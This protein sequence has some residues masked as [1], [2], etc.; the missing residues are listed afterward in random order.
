MKKFLKVIFCILFTIVFFI[1]CCVCIKIGLYMNEQRSAYKDIKKCYDSNAKYIMETKELNDPLGCY[2]KMFNLVLPYLLTYK[3]KLK[4]NVPLNYVYIDKDSTYYIPEFAIESAAALIG[5]GVG[6]TCKFEDNYVELF[7]K[8]VYAYDCGN[9]TNICA[10]AHFEPQCVGT[11]E[12]ALTYRSAKDFDHT[13]V[14]DNQ[15]HE[16]G[17]KIKE[18]GLENK[19]VLLKLNIVGAEDKVMDGILRYSDNIPVIL[20][21]IHYKNPKMMINKLKTL[22]TL[23]EKYYLVARKNVPVKGVV[24][25]IKPPLF[26]NKYVEG[27]YSRNVTLTYINKNLVE[28]AYLPFD[29]NDNVEFK[30]M[31]DKYKEKDLNQYMKINW[32]VVAFEKL[33]KLFGLSYE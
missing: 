3:V 31:V 4:N 21:Y 10:K 11:G 22:K 13:K 26:S 28:K 9:L 32:V 24:L 6:R 15:I 18:L 27:Y 23:N 17:D 7:K 33:K 12:N 2:P 29:Q 14:K 30:V 16:Y 25:E 8:P 1:G 20:L 19:Q 5:Y